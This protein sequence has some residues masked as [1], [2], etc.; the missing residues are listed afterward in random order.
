M[1]VVSRLLGKAMKLP[2][3]QSYAIKVKRNLK[4]PMPDGVM[5]LADR[6][7]PAGGG[8]L[9]LVRSVWP[10]QRVRDA[11]RYLIRRTLTP[12][13]PAAEASAGGQRGSLAVVSGRRA[14]QRGLVAVAR[15][16]ARDGCCWCW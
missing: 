9:V 4:I 13:Q 15:A 2:A 14:G 6:Y 16:T 11:V 8:P 3:A 7:I 5:L 1:T 10:R 12:G